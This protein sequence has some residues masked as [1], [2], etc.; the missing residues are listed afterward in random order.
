MKKKKS[1]SKANSVFFF[2]Y[3]MKILSVMV[4]TYLVNNKE[5]V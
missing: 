1:I 3:A 2:K 5:T 4:S